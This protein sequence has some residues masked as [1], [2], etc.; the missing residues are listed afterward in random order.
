MTTLSDNFPPADADA[1]A[2]AQV[3][4]HE[5]NKVIRVLKGERLKYTV[6]VHLPTGEVIEFQSASDPKLKFN[7]EA[8]ALWLCGGTYDNVPIMAWVPGSIL[9]VEEN[10]K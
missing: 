7:D 8:R 4:H 2:E 10:P 9:L 1:E 5:A 6:R 3:S